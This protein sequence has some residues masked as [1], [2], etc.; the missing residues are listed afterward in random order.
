MKNPLTAAGIEPTTFRFVAQHLNHCVLIPDNAT[1]IILELLPKTFPLLSTLALYPRSLDFA[2][3]S[4]GRQSILMPFPLTLPTQILH[5]P[6]YV[7]NSSKSSPV[8]HS[9]EY[10]VPSLYICEIPD[11][12]LDRCVGYSALHIF[13][14]RPPRRLPTKYLIQGQFCSLQ[15][16]FL[17]SFLNHT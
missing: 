7:N 17:I 10:V 16:F 8:S 9:A 3:W 1:E 13:R 15:Y 6:N 12:V 5:C 2:S 11:L 4:A 14:P